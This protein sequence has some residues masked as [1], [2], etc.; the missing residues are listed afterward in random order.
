MYC[1]ITGR[2]CRDSLSACAE[3]RPA[4]AVVAMA[5]A[6]YHMPKQMAHT[7]YCAKLFLSVGFLLSTKVS[8]MKATGAANT[9]VSFVKKA[10]SRNKPDK[11]NEPI[12]PLFE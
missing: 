10:R 4:D 11:I 3:V 1:T 12:F 8:R 2:R 6:A 9:A 7:A 5:R